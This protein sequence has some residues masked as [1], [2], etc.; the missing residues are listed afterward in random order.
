MKTLYVRIVA[1]F[2]GI[3]LISGLAAL[4]ITDYYYEYRLQDDN[5]ER[6][7]PIALEVQS[8]FQSAPAIGLDAYMEHVASLGYQIYLADNK[9]DVHTYG[10]PFKHDGIAQATVRQVLNGEAY[11]GSKSSHVLKIMG[12]FENSSRNTIGLP[13]Q[14]DGET[15]AMFIRPNLQQQIGEVRV[16]LGLLLSYA[17]VL[18][19]AFIVILTRTIVKPLQAMKK[20]TNKIVGGSY[21]V[22]LDV[23]RQDE[24]GD[25]ARH[26]SHMAGALERLDEMRQEFVA[27]VSHEFQT[28]VT[29]IHGFADAILRG[30]VT[31]E[32]QKQYLD[33]IHEESARL[34]SLSKQLLTLASL[35]KDTPVMKPSSFRLD[36]QIRHI[37]IVLE[38][39]WAR[40]RLELELDL[41]ATTITADESLLHHVWTNVIANAIKFSREDGSLAIAISEEARGVRVV[42]SDTGIGIPSHALPHIFDRFYKA[43]KARSRRDGGSGLGLA[44]CRKIVQLHGGTIQA[45]SE[46]GKGT[47]IALWLPRSF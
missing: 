37:L 10:D 21:K 33:I 23:K 12:Y 34:S 17:F 3:T 38:W 39:Q 36:E 42:V 14:D 27:N 26:F 46:E 1:S 18:I 9:L 28:P 5:R 29:S 20:A 47:S 24:I 2:I 40:K 19:L 16:L 13:L 44:I 30:E 15:Y 45:S 6:V 22:T 11:Y 8:F 7:L 32:E 4:F 43:D 35:D 41:P 31:P 25:L